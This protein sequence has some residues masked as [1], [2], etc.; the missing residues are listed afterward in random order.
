[1][2]IE[3]DCVVTADFRLFDGEGTLV[4]SSDE[5]G[6]LTY[7]HGAEELLPGLESA[8]AGHATGDAL[9]VEL[10][11]IIFHWLRRLKVWLDIR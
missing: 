10:T 4:D 1:M 9:S 8:L 2:K 11:K 6:S 5:G 7:L 3:K